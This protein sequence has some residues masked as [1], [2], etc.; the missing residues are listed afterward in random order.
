[1]GRV[2]ED[3]ADERV[4]SS[5]SVSYTNIRITIA[6]ILSINHCNAIF[7]VPVSLDSR[8]KV[9]SSLVVASQT[10]LYSDD[11]NH[12]DDAERG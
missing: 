10:A 2:D 7:H 4:N 3:A 5:S 1:M 9:F 6:I 8:R 12:D 11:P